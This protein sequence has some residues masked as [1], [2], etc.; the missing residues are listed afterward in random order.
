MIDCHIV[1]RDQRGLEEGFAES[2]ETEGADGL[3]E[4]QEVD[5]SLTFDSPNDCR[6]SHSSGS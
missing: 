2:E 4:K 1:R 5:F 3:M 6:P